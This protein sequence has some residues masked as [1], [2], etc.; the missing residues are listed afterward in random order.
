M[1]LTTYFI[2][3]T[4]IHQIGHSFSNINKQHSKRSEHTIKLLLKIEFK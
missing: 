2:F 4:E 3:I 1:I